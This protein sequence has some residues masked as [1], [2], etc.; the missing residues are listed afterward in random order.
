[1]VRC[2]TA[3]SPDPLGCAAPAASHL[4]GC[5]RDRS[6]PATG[7]AT[8]SNRTVPA[9]KTLTWVSLSRFHRL[10]C[11]DHARSRPPK[12]RRPSLSRVACMLT[13]PRRVCGMCDCWSGT[14]SPLSR[15]GARCLSLCL[16][17]AVQAALCVSVKA[18]ELHVPENIG[19]VRSRGHVL[20]C[21]TL[22]RTPRVASVAFW[23]RPLGLVRAAS[24]PQ[25]AWY[26]EEQPCKSEEQNQPCKGVSGPDRV[27]CMHGS[28]RRLGG[29]R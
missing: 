20:G 6:F 29:H 12:P 10:H 14:P 18:H 9:G 25:L 26:S 8:T 13:C 11:L 27:P 7:G 3:G 23:G 17:C 16:H 5:A 15:L 28:C 19:A 21:A 22:C 24:E 2:T 1:M 4:T